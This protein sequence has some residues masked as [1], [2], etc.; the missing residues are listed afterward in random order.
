MKT[1]VLVE[2]EQRSITHKSVN[3]D[4][5]TLIIKF[6]IG[7]NGLSYDTKRGY[8]MLALNDQNGIKTIVDLMH[9]M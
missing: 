1:S 3:C 9:R 5:F 6:D 8:Y 2:K 7:L 4:R